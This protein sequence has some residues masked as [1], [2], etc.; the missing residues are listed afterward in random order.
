MRNM[1]LTPSN[2][3]PP[4]STELPYFSTLHVRD[5]IAPCVW[6]FLTPPL[7]LLAVSVHVHV[8][9]CHMYLSL[10]I[11]VIDARRE[12]AATPLH[13]AARFQLSKHCTSQRVASA[14]EETPRLAVKQVEIKASGE[15]AKKGSEK[16][17]SS[18]SHKNY[19]KPSA[20]GLKKRENSGM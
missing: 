4:N 11:L 1:I 14:P 15:V 13:F 10:S 17:T 3:E 7:E 2:Y 6:E 19:L 5:A 20:F 9:I 8:Y 18:S 16:A 12:N